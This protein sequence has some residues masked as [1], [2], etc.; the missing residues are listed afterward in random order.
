MAH[1][2]VLRIL[3][4]QVHGTSEA[5]FEYLAI[6]ANACPHPVAVAEDLETVFPHVKEVVMIDVALRETTVD[7]GAGG[8]ASIH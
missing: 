1:Q 6:L 5:V 7:V 3:P 8:D 2:D 4:V